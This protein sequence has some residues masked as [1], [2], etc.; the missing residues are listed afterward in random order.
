M[1]ASCE[2]SRIT[3]SRTNSSIV[4]RGVD[5]FKNPDQQ[6]LH[7]YTPFHETTHGIRVI[8][9]QGDKKQQQQQSYHDSESEL[10]S[11]NEEFGS[12]TSSFYVGRDQT[13]R[14]KT[15]E[16][17]STKII[18]IFE[19]FVTNCKTMYNP[20]EYLTVDKKIIPFKGRC[21]F[22][23]YLPNKPAKYGIKTYVLCWSHTSYV[24]N[25]GIYAGKQPEGP[26]QI[27]NSPNNVVERLA[28]PIS[29][30]KRNITTEN[31][32]ISYPLAVAILNEH[33]LTLVGTLKK[34]KKEIPPEFM[35]NRARQVFSSIFGFQKNV[36]LVSY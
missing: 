24:V 13:T 15:S 26:Y 16:W 9:T 8:F 23:Q 5:L 35:T 19:E 21:S 20:G 25:L 31:W 32:Y 4:R 30:S 34:N 10:E 6:K 1:K 27:S 29:G 22:K 7:P 12:S 36:S 33:K 2:T 28:L 14:W 17:Q 18:E 3:Q 11:E